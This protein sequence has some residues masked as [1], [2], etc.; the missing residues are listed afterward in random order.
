MNTLLLDTSYNGK[1]VFNTTSLESTPI[2]LLRLLCQ[3]AS[4]KEIKVGVI[5]HLNG[6]YGIDGK[7]LNAAIHPEDRLI[8]S[9]G[10]FSLATAY[11]LD[12]VLL[13]DYYT[14]KNSDT[15]AAYIT[16]GSELD[17]EKWLRDSVSASINDVANA[18]R[19]MKSSLPVGL[20]VASVWAN[21]TTEGG[22]PTNSKFEA[23]WDGYADTKGIISDHLVDFVNV[24]IP[25]TTTNNQES[26]TLL[27]NWWGKVCSDAKLPLYITHEANNMSNGELSGWNATDQLTRQV[28]VARRIAS[29]SGSVYNGVAKLK[30]NPGGGTDY[31]MK[32]YDDQISDADALTNLTITSPEKRS[33]VTYEQEIQ[34]RGRFDPNEEVTLNGEKIEP[35][36]RGGFSE[37]RDLKVGTNT[38]TFSHKGRST[39]F[40]IERKVVIFQSVSPSKNMKVPGGSTVNFDVMAYRDSEIT[41]SINGKNI[42]LTMGGGGEGNDADSM[43]VSYEGSYVVPAATNKEQS[44][45]QVKFT[46]SYQ[47][48]IQYASGGTITIE[49][50]PD[51]T[52]PDQLTGQTLPHAVVNLTY[53]NTYP[54]LTTPSYPQ[55]ILFQLPKGTQDIV[56]SESGNFLHLRSGKTIMKGAATILDKEFPGNNQVSQLSYGVEGGDTVFRFSMNWNSPFSLNLS[57]YPSDQ[58]GTTGNFRFS[59]T[60]VTLLLDYVTAVSPDGISG[61]LGS[62]PIFSNIT[63]EKVYNKD[64]KIYQMKVTLPLRQAGRYY[65]CHAEWEDNTLILRFNHP[66]SGGD[67]SGVKICVDPG[68]GGTDTGTTAGRDVLEKTANLEQGLAVAAALEAR[69]ATVILTRSSDKTVG[70]EQKVN[71]AEANKCDL[72]IAIHHNSAGSN[73]TPSGVQTYFNAPFSQPL[74]QYVQAQLEGVMPNKGWNGAKSSVPNYNFI[75]TREKQYPSILVECGYL[76]NPNDEALAMDP[77]HQQEMAEAIA[78]GVIDYYQ[79]FN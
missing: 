24:Y 68:H 3:K 28:I 46:G 51:E 61:D 23:F 58:F 18:I 64:R 67:L 27:A 34:F 11:E 56:V 31:L 48:S 35:S 5:Y 45:G 12:S 78:Q 40:T 42:K 7:L 44:I 6:T 15:Y 60:Q 71:I 69:G 39:T 47:G 63:T 72:Y 2:D 17:Y 52:E 32:Y 22:T 53:A 37:W 65:G 10:A 57:P 43:Y 74:A 76:S 30:E 20:S 4:E 70:N 9:Q 41:A 8:L 77:I 38:F 54:Y 25:T 33:F 62:S 1:V 59:A 19:T 75:V 29:F 36:E 49:K 79:A 16:Y 66:A 14:E 55:G 73:P 13:D 21:K 50:L 26:F